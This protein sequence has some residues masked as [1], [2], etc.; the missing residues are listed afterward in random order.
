MSVQRTFTCDGPD[1]GDGTPLNVTT[2]AEHPPTFITTF[3]EPG[4]AHEPR[5]EMHFCSWD[6]VL[7]YAAKVEPSEIIHFPDKESSDE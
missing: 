4:F 1:C 2:H 6:C 5:H 3:E 7:K